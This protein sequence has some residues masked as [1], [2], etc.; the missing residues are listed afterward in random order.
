MEESTRFL[1]GEALLTFDEVVRIASV[2]HRMGVRTLRLTGGEPLRRRAIVE[3]VTRLSSLGF[4]DLAMTT[5]GVGLARLSD[6]LKRAGLRR[7]NISCDSLRAD[8]FPRIRRRGHLDEVLRAMAAAA[9][10]GLVPLKVNVVL[11]AGVN[12]DEIEDFAVFARE[13]KR[14]VRFIE[15]MPLDAGRSWARDRLVPSDTVLDRIVARWPLQPVGGSDTS[16]A[17]RYRFSDGEGEIGVVS[18]VT[19]PFC[20]SCNRL[21]LTAD[22]AVRNCLFSDDEVSVRDLMRGGGSDDDIAG[23]FRHAVGAKLAGHGINEPGFLQ[24]KRTMSMI[25]G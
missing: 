3:L 25:G 18:S 15:F 9:A 10:A 19:R 8:R 11:L 20:G 12:D 23:L 16:P 17:E 2:A 14:I 22:G 5:N 4:S 24:P 6:D 1:S 13:T 7:V 21:R